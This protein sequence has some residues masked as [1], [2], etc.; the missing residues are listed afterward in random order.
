MRSC[1]RC[2]LPVADGY[3]R[4]PS[5]GRGL[6][7]VHALA[8]QARRLTVVGLVGALVVTAAALGSGSADG[9]WLRADVTGV[10]LD[11]AGW[12]A[13]V[14]VRN[15]GAASA[16]GSCRVSSVR[17]SAV[18]SAAGVFATPRLAVGQSTELTVP[19]SV[20]RGRPDAEALA[21]GCQ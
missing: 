3:R 8:C 5:C 15:D 1:W 18:E 14:R 4:C 7:V 20:T 6:G 21:V 11:E 16:Q 10:G 19:L 13:I 17:G 12:H 9:A 2:G